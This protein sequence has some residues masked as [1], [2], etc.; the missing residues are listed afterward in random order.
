MTFTQSPSLSNN[1]W[2]ILTNYLIYTVLL[3]VFVFSFVILKDVSLFRTISA[4]QTE[5]FL[6]LLWNMKQAFCAPPKFSRMAEFIDCCQ[7]HPLNAHTRQNKKLTTLELF[8]CPCY[9]QVTTTTRSKATTITTKTTTM[10]AT[11]IKMT[12]KWRNIEK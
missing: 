10:T 6:L 12:G 8:W 9:L 4:L 2:M 11:T 5:L 1:P 7:Q 3:D